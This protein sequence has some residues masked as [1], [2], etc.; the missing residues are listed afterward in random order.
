MRAVE[1]GERRQGFRVVSGLQIGSAE[2]VVD[3]IAEVAG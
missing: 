3:V 1:V 2:V